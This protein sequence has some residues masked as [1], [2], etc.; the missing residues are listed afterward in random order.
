LREPFAP[1]SL[2]MHFRSFTADGRAYRER[3]IAGKTYRYFADQGRRL[4]SVWSDI[5]GMSANTPLRKEGTGYP[6]Q[7]PERLLERIIR[8]ASHP[9]HTVGDLMCGSGTTLVV[10]ARLGRRFV[11]ADM[12]AI[13]IETTSRR[14]EQAGTSYRLAML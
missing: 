13:A 4:G 11:G 2:E 7:K 6:T 10:A 12:S 8:A 3:T 14:L 1:T 9:G 5:P